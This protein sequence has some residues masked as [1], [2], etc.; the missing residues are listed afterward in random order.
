[1]FI[2][3]EEPFKIP[4]KNFKWRGPMRRRTR[5]HGAPDHEYEGKNRGVETVDKIWFDPN[6][7]YA[8]EIGQNEIIEDGGPPSDSNR[9]EWLNN[10]D[11]WETGHKALLAK[12]AAEAAAKGEKPEGRPDE[13]TSKKESQKK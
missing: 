2:P 13:G 11:E 7:N 12:Q 8:T 1:P 10:M 5:W 6:A 3:G 4:A 9:S